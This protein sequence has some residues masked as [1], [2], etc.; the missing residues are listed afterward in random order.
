MLQCA[1]H[2]IR[3]DDAWLKRRPGRSRRRRRGRP[4][5]PCRPPSTGDRPPAIRLGSCD[6]AELE[7]PSCPS[8]KCPHCSVTRVSRTTCHMGV[9]CGFP[10]N[11]VRRVRVRPSAGLRQL[12]NRADPAPQHLR[13]VDLA[14]LSGH[15]RRPD[16]LHSPPARHAVPVDLLAVRGLHHLL[17]HHAPDGSRP[18]LL[19]L[20]PAGRPDQAGDCHRVGQHGHRP[21]AD[22]AA[23]P[24]HAHAPR[25]GARDR[26]AQ[27]GR[28][29]AARERG[30]VPRHLRERRRRHRPQG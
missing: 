24:G 22:R 13:R 18:V 10:R 1:R 20:L 26:R 27:A 12:V 15:P 9:S 19:A 4:R 7:C 11:V 17:R 29:G 30:A 21:G 2:T 16:L 28:S 5:G 23:G 8:R 3:I 25:A 14:L 6:G